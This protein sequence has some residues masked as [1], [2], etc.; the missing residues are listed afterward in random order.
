MPNFAT[1]NINSFGAV[2]AFP[3]FAAA[4]HLDVPAKTAI[5]PVVSDSDPYLGQ[6]LY[7]HWL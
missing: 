3:L 6:E 7:S 1:P 4:S 2:L 5:D